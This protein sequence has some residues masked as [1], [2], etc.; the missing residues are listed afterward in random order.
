MPGRV[1]RPTDSPTARRSPIWIRCAAMKSIR[2]AAAAATVVL[3]VAGVGAACS[4]G[5]G[6][7]SGVATSTAAPTG[8]TTAPTAT[9]GEGPVGPEEAAVAAALASYQRA[10][11]AG[12]LAG[13]C[14]LQTPETGTALIMAVQATGN[15]VT[16]CEDA[17]GAVLAQPGARE[18][19]MEAAT[20]TT[21]QEVTVD[22]LNATITWTSQRQGQS[23]TDDVTL[24]SIDGLWRVAGSG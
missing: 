17:L 3:I 4:V 7:T 21:V 11:A 23:R 5:G 20:T 9:A 14:R 6:E 12:D 16:T 18:T 15:Q 8:S 1:G 19:A 22:G 24:Q 13:A 2:T 10:L